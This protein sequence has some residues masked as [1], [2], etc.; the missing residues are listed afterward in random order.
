M[1]LI[2]E[3]FHDIFDSEINLNQTVQNHNDF[4]Y[5]FTFFQISFLKFL[6]NSISNNIYFIIFTNLDLN[7]D[8]FINNL[9]FLNISY[10]HIP[11]NSN[12]FSIQ[13]DLNKCWTIPSVPIT[14]QLNNFY[15]EFLNQLLNTNSNII[16]E[17]FKLS[18]NQYIDYLKNLHNIKYENMS[19][20]KKQ[21]L[22]DLIFEHKDNMSDFANL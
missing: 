14:I 6:N 17:D 9:I 21:L 12:P 16:D 8:F 11:F 4:F 15:N 20:G 7:F 2:V 10:L 1:S 5:G 19:M 3:R 18:F 13:I 22:S